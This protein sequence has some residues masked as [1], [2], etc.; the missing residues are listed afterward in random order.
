M[1][2]Y[3]GF[4]LGTVVLT[5]LLGLGLAAGPARPPASDLESAWGEWKNGNVLQAEQ[6]ASKQAATDSGKHLLFLC[7]FVKGAYEEALALYRKVGPGYEKRNELDEPVFHAYLH[8]G[9]VAEARDHARE[10]KL[11]TPLQTMVELRVRHPFAAR[12]EEVAVVPFA[13]HPL[14]PY[15]PA[16]EAELE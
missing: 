12:L 4:L 10:R 1:K 7:A 11:S 6:L 2:V 14:T 16:F 13:Q 8:L 9:R 15:F 3:L 5:A